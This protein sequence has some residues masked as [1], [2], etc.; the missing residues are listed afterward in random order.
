MTHAE[1]E[2][3]KDTFLN[4]PKGP[5]PGNKFI[6]SMSKK[7]MKGM[8]LSMEKTASPKH[9][10]KTKFASKDSYGDRTSP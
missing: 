8:S 9:L 5:K 7:D 3:E 1:M 4:Y 10:T 6:S 2:K